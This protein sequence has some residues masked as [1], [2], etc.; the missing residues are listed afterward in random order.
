MLPVPRVLLKSTVALATARVL[1]LLQRQG[2]RSCG[3]LDFVS[4][5]ST[6]ISTYEDFIISKDGEICPHHGL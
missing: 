4:G 5:Y 1:L 3:E 2:E 6:A